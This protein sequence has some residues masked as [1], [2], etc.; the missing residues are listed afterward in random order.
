MSEKSTLE[1]EVGDGEL[2]AEDERSFEELGVDTR[3]IHALSKKGVDKPTPIQR[4]A[5]PLILV[6][7]CVCIY[8]CL[9]LCFVWFRIDKYMFLLF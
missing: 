6:C 2:A 4:S 8:M 9:C 5:I 1:I 7:I 3:L